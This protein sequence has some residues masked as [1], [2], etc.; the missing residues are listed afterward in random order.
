[1]LNFASDL[2][3][4]DAFVHVST[5]YANGNSGEIGEVIYPTRNSPEDVMDLLEGVPADK[6]FAITEK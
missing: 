2:K 5:A 6:A 4:V 1:M 3:S